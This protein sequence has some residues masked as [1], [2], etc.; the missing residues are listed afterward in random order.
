M[1][2]ESLFV[3]YWALIYSS[4]LEVHFLSSKLIWCISRKKKNQNWKWNCKILWKSSVRLFCRA[5]PYYCKCKTHF[6]YILDNWC[7]CL[8]F[9]GIQIQRRVKTLVLRITWQPYLVPWPCMQYTGA[10]NSPHFKI[11]CCLPIL[12]Q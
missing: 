10:F 2:F 11:A 5:K 12:C 3:S 7:T 9:N 8:Q 6:L 4:K 1:Y